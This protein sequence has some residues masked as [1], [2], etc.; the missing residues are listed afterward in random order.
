M[1]TFTKSSTLEACEIF[2]F[3]FLTKYFALRHTYQ[4]FI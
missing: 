2:G 4:H 1:I 3:A